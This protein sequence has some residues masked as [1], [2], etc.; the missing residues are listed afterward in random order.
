MK[1][2]N[3]KTK[4]IRFTV[5]E[6][7][8]IQSN[9]TAHGRCLWCGF[10]LQLGRYDKRNEIVNGKKQRVPSKQYCATSCNKKYI[11]FNNKLLRHKESNN[12]RLQIV[13]DMVRFQEIA[14]SRADHLNDFLNNFLQNCL[15]ID[16]ILSFQ[17]NRIK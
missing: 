2:Q 6:K 8:T 5:S 7:K 4:S 15:Q 16:H 11:Q 1:L 9:R 3:L 12:Q 10:G 17:S 14:R 13:I